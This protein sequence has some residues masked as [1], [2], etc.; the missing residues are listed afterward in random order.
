MRRDEMRR[1]TIVGRDVEWLLIALHTVRIY[2]QVSS[3][4]RGTVYAGLPVG[5]RFNSLSGASIT[6]LQFLTVYLVTTV[7]S[8]VHGPPPE[9][10]FSRSNLA[11]V[12]FIKRI[13]QTTRTSCSPLTKRTIGQVRYR[14]MQIYK[15]RSPRGG[16]KQA[17]GRFAL[18]K[19]LFIERASH[20]TLFYQDPFL[21]F[22]LYHHEDYY[23]CS[24]LPRCSERI[25]DSYSS[26]CCYSANH[27]CR[28]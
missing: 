22:L 25:G 28:G 16:S 20:R 15:T 21:L 24:L 23:Y 13:D 2:I 12:L 17:S 6:S 4:R 14:Y 26:R 11:N 10:P 8:T 9:R 7:R 18:E 5:L 27:E 1:D 19:Y 3:W